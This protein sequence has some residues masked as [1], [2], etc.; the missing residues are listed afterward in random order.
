MP[1]F[2][3]HWRFGALFARVRRFKAPMNVIYD[4]DGQQREFR[5]WGRGIE[6]SQ[7]NPHAYRCFPWHQQSSW[8]GPIESAIRVGPHAYTCKSSSKTTGVVCVQLGSDAGISPPS[9]EWF[10]TGV[11]GYISRPSA[12]RNPGIEYGSDL[13]SALRF[14]L[15]DG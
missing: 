9:A 8:S 14:L 10:G 1:C 15:C 12:E 3:S 5:A 11:R 13:G 2:F 7:E 6:C 4:W